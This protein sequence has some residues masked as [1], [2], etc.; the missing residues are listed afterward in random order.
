MPRRISCSICRTTAID[1]FS[2][3]TGWNGIAYPQIG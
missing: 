3:V 2:G 1:S